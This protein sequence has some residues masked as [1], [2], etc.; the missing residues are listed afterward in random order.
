MPLRIQKINRTWFLPL[1][2]IPLRAKDE[3]DAWTAKMNGRKFYRSV[4]SEKHG[5]LEEGLGFLP[6]QEI[7]E[8]FNKVLI[9]FS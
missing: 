1:K 3:T 8:S 9:L 2:K 6:F 4:I 7:I 5:W